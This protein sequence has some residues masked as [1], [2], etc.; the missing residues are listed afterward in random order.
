MQRW[1]PVEN[2]AVVILHL[3]LDCVAV[4]NDLVVARSHKAKV[5]ALSVWAN[6]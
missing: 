4:T 1:L 5:N 3:P 6:D 2:D